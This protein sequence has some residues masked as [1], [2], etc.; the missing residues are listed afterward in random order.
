MLHVF[1][2]ALFCVTRDVKPENLLVRSGS[3]GAEEDSLHLR[4]IDL[5]SALDA[6][7][8]RHL[9]GPHGPSAAEQ[10]ME[11]APPEAVLG[12]LRVI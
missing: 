4:L 6:H 1:I 2:F 10:T 9:Y 7:S 5:G 3:G 8:M 11:Y 12:R